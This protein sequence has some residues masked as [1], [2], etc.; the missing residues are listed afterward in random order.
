M[1]DSVLTRQQ[2]TQFRTTLACDLGVELFRRWSRRLNFYFQ[3]ISPLLFH[4]FSHNIP[5]LDSLKAPN[6]LKSISTKNTV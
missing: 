1:L 6:V 4:A 3:K 5:D 2:A